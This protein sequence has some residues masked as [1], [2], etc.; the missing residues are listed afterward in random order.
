[1]VPANIRKEIMRRLARAEREEDV[2]I[3]LAIESGSRAWGLLRPIVTLM[4]A[5][6]MHVI[7]IGILPSI[8]KS[9]AML[10]SMPLLTTLT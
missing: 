8:C 6:F 10:S 2:C 7:L 4:F 1:M 5:S 3:L 9:V